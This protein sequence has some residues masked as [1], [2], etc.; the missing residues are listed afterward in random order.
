MYL[1]ELS[2][3]LPRID[4]NPVSHYNMGIIMLLR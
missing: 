4:K 3:F 2:V 1:S